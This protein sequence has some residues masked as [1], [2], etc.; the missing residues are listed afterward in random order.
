MATI[1]LSAVGAAIGG[2]FGGTVLGLSGAVIGRAVGATLGRVI[3]QR[4]MGSGSSVVEVGRV[5]RIR[6]MGA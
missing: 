5:E 6:V 3:D 4:L 1:V 2:S